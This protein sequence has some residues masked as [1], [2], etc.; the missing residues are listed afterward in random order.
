MDI[1]TITAFG[2]TA[3]SFIY[4]I[5]YLARLLTHGDLPSHCQHCALQQISQKRK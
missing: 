2:L 3:I 4:I 1:Q 5:R